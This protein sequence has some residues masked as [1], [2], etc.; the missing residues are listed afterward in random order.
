LCD[1]SSNHSFEFFICNFIHFTV[2]RFHY[3]GIV[4][5]FEES[6]CI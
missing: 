6:C 5:F 4:D 3:L 1:Y 2:I